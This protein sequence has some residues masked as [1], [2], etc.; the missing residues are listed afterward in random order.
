[1]HSLPQ[2]SLMELFIAGI[3]NK[4]KIC[5]NATEP[6]SLDL[7]HGA[8]F[9]NGDIISLMSPQQQLQGSIHLECL[10]PTMEQVEMRYNGLSGTLDLEHLPELLNCLLIYGNA[11][12]GTVCLTKLPNNLEVLNIGRNRL[13]GTLDFTQLPPVMRKLYVYNNAF[14]GSCDFS[15]IPDSF[16]CLNVSH[17]NLAGEITWKEGLLL[18]VDG[19]DVKVLGIPEEGADDTESD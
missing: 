4:E 7:W 1:M 19:T 11:F 14:Y 3:T 8:Q 12:T 10:P 17:T 9:R 5:G 15:K 13:E 2:Q 18:N 16:E 6:N